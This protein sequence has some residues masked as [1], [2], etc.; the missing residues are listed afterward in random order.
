LFFQVE[1]LNLN[2]MIALSEFNIPTLINLLSNLTNFI[3]K[4]QKNKKTLQNF[5]KYTNV[6]HYTG[7]HGKNHRTTVND[8]GR[9][10]SW[11]QNAPFICT[12]TIPIHL[13]GK[14]NSHRRIE[15]TSSRRPR[16]NTDR[17]D[18]FTGLGFRDW[19]KATD[20]KRGILVSRSESRNHQ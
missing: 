13:C 19:Q 10:Q 5:E 8:R 11:V 2:F 12:V 18:I 9:Q 7:T 15:Y 17:N 4:K 20:L 3:K 1:H 14:F 6:D 16:A